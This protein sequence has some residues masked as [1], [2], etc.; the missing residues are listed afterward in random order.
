MGNITKTVAALAA[1]LTLTAAF[2][3]PAQAKPKWGPALGVGIVAGTMLGA[4]AASSAYAGPR[5]M[6][7]DTF[8]A[9]GTYAGLRWVCKVWY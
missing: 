7:V 2:A 9:W 3:A 4:A 5:C 8:D 6:Y 1:A